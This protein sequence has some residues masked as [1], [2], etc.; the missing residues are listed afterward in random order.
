MKKAEVLALFPLKGKVTLEI[1]EKAVLMDG[2]N[3]IGALT[4]KEALGVNNDGR[5]LISWMSVNGGIMAENIDRDFHYCVLTTEEEVR[6]M[7]VVEPMEVTFII[8]TIV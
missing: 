3:C 5:N 6:M 4:L 1:I 7:Q 2:G 8:K